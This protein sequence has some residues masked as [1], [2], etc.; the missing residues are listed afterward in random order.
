[1]NP[2]N[3]SDSSGEELKSVS[4][5]LSEAASKLSSAEQVVTELAS[6]KSAAAKHA[7]TKPASAEPSSAE[8]IFSKLASSKGE[9]MAE[10]LCSILIIALATSMFLNFIVI[11]GRIMDRAKEREKNMHEAVAFLEAMEGKAWDRDVWGGDT[12]GGD[13]WDGDIWDEEAWDE[14]AW[15]EDTWD[16]DIRDEDTWDEDIRDEDTRNKDIIAESDIGE[17]TVS[18]KSKSGKI[19]SKEH[20]TVNV[21]YGPYG[22]AYR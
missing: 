11:S 22:A 2:Y 6:A 7:I 12:W 15:N 16:G 21:Y 3:Q 8:Q 17:L 4:G 9:T 13:T 18:I 5:V 14:E 20:F 19:I 1:M 10:S